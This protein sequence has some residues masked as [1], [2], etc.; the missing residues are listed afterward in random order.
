MATSNEADSTDGASWT[1]ETLGPLFHATE[2]KHDRPFVLKY[3]LSSTPT[4][5][6]DWRFHRHVIRI[7]LYL[8]ERVQLRIGDRVALVAAVGP[9]WAIA[10]W[11]ALTQGVSTATFERPA[12][13]AALAEQLG[14][15]GPRVVFADG[16]AVADV[17]AWSRADPDKGVT[18]IALNGVAVAPAIAWTEALDLGGTLD[19]AERANAYRGIMRSLPPETAALAHAGPNGVGTVWRFL[20]HREV[21]R[22]VQRIWESARISPGDVGYVAGGAPSLFSTVAFLAFSADGHT[23]V[24]LGT[25]GSAI[26]EIRA[27]DPTKIV[28]PAAVAE[29]LPD[30]IP[31]IDT[32]RVLGRASRW[33]AQAR[34]IARRARQEAK[35]AA[36][37][38]PRARWLGTGSALDASIRDR[39]GRTMTIDLDPG[40]GSAEQT[41]AHTR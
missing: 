8:H 13:A 37:L 28:V 3:G 38:R 25:P 10:Q 4:E 30:A 17:L 24:L 19:T 36:E 27:S 20:S 41:D 33:L 40:L 2:R 39:L 7:A 18:V 15:L 34:A 32:S 6:P 11:A 12:S 9:E 1:P 26:E 29:Q 21:V 23:Q 5:M 14:A 31:G 22:R 35:S 16:P